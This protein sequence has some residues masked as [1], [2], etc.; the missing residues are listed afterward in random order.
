[1]FELNEIRNVAT[2]GYDTGAIYGGRD[3]SS[4]VRALY[5]KHHRHLHVLVG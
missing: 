1:M 4:R 3:L 2:I 5:Y